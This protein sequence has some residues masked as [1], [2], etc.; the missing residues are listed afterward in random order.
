MV[1]K[2]ALCGAAL[3]VA[4]GTAQAAGARA[5]TLHDTYCVMCHDTRVY[6]RKERVANDYPGIRAQVARWQG[7]VMLNW[8]D[9]DIDLVASYLAEQY[10]KVPCPVSC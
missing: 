9:E 10:Y 5:R 6:T 3:F 8:S 7:N 2:L 1:R 4:A